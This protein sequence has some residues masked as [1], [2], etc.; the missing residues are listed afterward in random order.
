MN[1]KEK[2]TKKRNKINLINFSF[3]KLKNKLH[4]KSKI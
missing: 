3:K 2:N 1:L 4:L